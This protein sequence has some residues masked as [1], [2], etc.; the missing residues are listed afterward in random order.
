MFSFSVNISFRR[1]M[2]DRTGFLR[3]LVL[4]SESGLR[5]YLYSLRVDFAFNDLSVF[6]SSDAL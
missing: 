5:E 1:I 2:T 6:A 3:N 4:P